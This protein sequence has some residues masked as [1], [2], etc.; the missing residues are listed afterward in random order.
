MSERE[1]L[2]KGPR[3]KLAVP[4]SVRSL[5]STQTHAENGISLP[6]KPTLLQC[7]SSSIFS[8]TVCFFR[9]PDL[10]LKN[11][12]VLGG[13][14]LICLPSSEIILKKKAAL[15]KQQKTQCAC[16]QSSLSREQKRE[17]ESGVCRIHQIRLGAAEYLVCR[18][19]RNAILSG[20]KSP[21]QEHKD[22]L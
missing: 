20:K 9:R 16:V 2:K 13:S 14:F 1:R 5:R 15:P 12:A 21:K 10:L 8:P 19:T 6:V 11:V 17:K 3:Q 22:S 7:S 4:F 18:D